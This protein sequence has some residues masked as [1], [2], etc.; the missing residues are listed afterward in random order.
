MSPVSSRTDG[1]S[2]HRHTNRAA[3]AVGRRDLDGRGRPDRLEGFAD[4][5]AKEPEQEARLGGDL[6]APSAGTPVVIDS[7]GVAASGVAVSTG[8]IVGGASGGT[9]GMFGA[10]AS[11]QHNYDAA[12]ADCRA[13]H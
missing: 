6:T 7:R 8:A 1:S 10:G 5:P 12:Y 11:W 13:A 2:T 9:V 4:G 3:V